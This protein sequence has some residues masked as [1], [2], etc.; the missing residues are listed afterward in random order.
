MSIETLDDAT[1]LTAWRSGDTAAA[2]QLLQRHFIAVYRFFAANLAQSGSGADPDDLTQRTFEAC[3]KR[4]DAVQTDFRSYL[5]GVAR[6]LLYDEWRRRKAGGP[7]QTPSEAAIQDVR[8]SPSAAVARL[9]EQRLFVAQVQQLPQEF[10]SVIELFFWE[11]RAVNDIAA[12][13]GIPV[14]T[15]KS[16]LFRGRAMLRD[17]LLSSGAPADLRSMA[18]A[19]LDADSKA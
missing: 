8:T 19:R 4:K 3:I 9:D 15:V 7:T 1:L 14:G 18:L 10:R 2:G 6:N 17:G 11:D 13:L 16:R 5:F 12:H